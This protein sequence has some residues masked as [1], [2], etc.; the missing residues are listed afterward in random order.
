MNN[1]Y[2]YLEVNNAKF[3]TAVCLPEGN[4]SYPTVIFRSPY[5][6]YAEELTENE[7]VARIAEEHK[8][9]IENG[10]AIVYQHCRGRGNP[11]LA[12]GVALRMQA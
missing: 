3:F 7:I 11:R 2:R 6:D 1:F 9:F 12:I 8:S 10:Y 4:G 5:V